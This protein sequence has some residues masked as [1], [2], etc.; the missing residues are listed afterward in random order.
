[1]T[2]WL[3]L[4]DEVEAVARVLISSGYRLHFFMNSIDDQLVDGNH[5]ENQ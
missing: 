1:M 5:L 3:L 2:H 4:I